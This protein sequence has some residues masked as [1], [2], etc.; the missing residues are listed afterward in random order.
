[1]PD[2]LSTFTDFAIKPSA[3][4]AAGVILFGVVWGFFKGVESVL[5]ED[6]KL[7][8][9]VWLLGVKAAE[10]VQ[11]WPDTFAKVF[12]R[13]FGKRYL[14][15]RSLLISTLLS[16]FL[17]L[18]VVLLAPN[19]YKALPLSVR[20]REAMTQMGMTFLFGKAITDYISLLCTRLLLH[21]MK[22]TQASWLWSSFVAANFL[23]TTWLAMIGLT[24]GLFF[25]GRFLKWY[26]PRYFVD[27]VE[28]STVINIALLLPQ[29]PL[30]F[31]VI[32]LRTTTTFPLL[33]SGFS[34]SI[35]LWLYA[36]SGFILKF[37]RRFDIGFQ[38]FNRKFDIE[39]K[40]LQSIGLVSGA[41]VAV[42]YWAAVIVARSV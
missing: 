2:G 28:W 33:L 7:E 3:P 25:G 31:A 9:A 15:L 41:L 23:L 20:V 12:D 30:Q 29:H 34:A 16:L 40:P 38:W 35:W 4:F 39:K 24:V 26:D 10:N 17:G 1:M 21:L 8:I 18:L 19:P 27:Q 22:R 13:V 11:S 42:I 5:N 32:V 14:S 6:T 36:G 37:A